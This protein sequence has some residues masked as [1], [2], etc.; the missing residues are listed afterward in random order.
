MVKKNDKIYEYN[1]DNV[2]I[3]VHYVYSVKNS[4]GTFELRDKKMSRFYLEPDEKGKLIQAN[5]KRGPKGSI[6]YVECAKT[7]R[8][9]VIMSLRLRMVKFVENCKDPKQLQELYGIIKNWEQGGTSTQTNEA[10]DTPGNNTADMED[11]QETTSRTGTGDS[12]PKLKK[13]KK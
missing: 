2:M 13:A 3:S 11:E 8:D 5:K 10:Q 4:A 1:T 7:K 6:F 12:N 9:L